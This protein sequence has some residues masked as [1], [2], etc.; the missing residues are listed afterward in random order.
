MLS[1]VLVNGGGSGVDD[2]MMVTT[3]PLLLHVAD[4]APVV[5]STGVSVHPPQ[6]VSGSVDGPWMGQKVGG[7]DDEH[8]KG[9][10][11][12]CGG[13]N[14]GSSSHWSTHPTPVIHLHD[15]G[16]ATLS[17]CAPLSMSC[18]LL[19]PPVILP[20][21]L[22]PLLVSVSH[23]LPTSAVVIIGVGGSCW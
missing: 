16:G 4:L 14:S 3:T 9:T 7:M 19:M 5:V 22:P 1:C 12:R 23:P 10:E 15:D 20:L 17:D 6:S 11:R 2:R 13:G 21:S 18:A 8:H